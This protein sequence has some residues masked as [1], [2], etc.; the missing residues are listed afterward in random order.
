MLGEDKANLLTFVERE[1]RTAFSMY[2]WCCREKTATFIVRLL[3]RGVVIFRVSALSAASCC[4]RI[5]LPNLSY[6]AVA[7]H[8]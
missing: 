3:S 5:A 2:F 8:Y 1:C 7:S 4:P 6:P